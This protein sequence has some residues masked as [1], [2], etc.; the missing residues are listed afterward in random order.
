M[1]KSISLRLCTLIVLLF[2]G[3]SS[4]AQQVQVKGTVVE[5]SSGESIIGASV[6]EVGSN[7]NG[8]ITDIDGN[9][10]LS[11]A[12][13]VLSACKSFLRLY[14]KGKMPMD[15]NSLENFEI[16]ADFIQQNTFF[17][18]LMEPMYSILR[19]KNK[20]NNVK[21]EISNAL[22]ENLEADFEALF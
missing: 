2:A 15:D 11:V 3:I 12:S 4:F 8:T 5:K 13:G 21:T 16:H 7:S 20:Q 1:L 6:M 14:N 19:D 22:L 18:E 10:I 17:G 9:F